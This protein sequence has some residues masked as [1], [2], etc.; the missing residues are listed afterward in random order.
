MTTVSKSVALAA[1]KSALQMTHASKAAHIGSSLSMIDILSVIVTGTTLAKDGE[2]GEELIISKGHA[3]AGAYAVLAHTGYIPLEL[4]E[5]YSADGALLGGH[6]TSTH[7]SAI[8]LSTGS[9]GHGLPFS[10][11]RALA[12]KRM[13]IQ[14]QSFTLLS[15]GECDE[16]SNWEAALLASHLKL[17][18]L[19]AVIDRNF[20]QSLRST[21]DTVQLEPLAEKWLAFNWDVAVVNGHSHENLY[22]A[23][24][25]KSEKPMMTIANTVKGY[26]VSFMEN[27]VDWHYKSPSSEELS[28][29]INEL[30][31]FL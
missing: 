4:I 20:L 7:V 8:N 30:D 21:E 26:G 19:S 1:R 25:R 9:L 10:V 29:A 14:G 11:G 16:G 28:K 24:F 13:G 23:I 12:K 15:D 3:A 27:S 6:V 18:N 31:T 22:Q 2:L 17:N 5:S